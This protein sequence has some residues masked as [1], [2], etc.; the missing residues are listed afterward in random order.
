VRAWWERRRAQRE[1]ADEA[2]R[3]QGRALVE[4]VAAPCVAAGSAK[5]EFTREGVVLRPAAPDAAEVTVEADAVNIDIWIGPLGSDMFLVT[6]DPEW[7]TL[8]ALLEAVIDGRYTER[9][10]PNGKRVVMTMAFDLPGG[11]YVVT[12]YGAASTYG[13]P[14]ERRYAAYGVHPRPSG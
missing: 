6:S 12:H 8:R 3:D 14:G 13:P 1:Q 10:V 5:V 4:E 9:V 7:Q 2:A 11:D